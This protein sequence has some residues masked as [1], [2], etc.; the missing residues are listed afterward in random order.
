M[1]LLNKQDSYPPEQR[2]YAARVADILKNLGYTPKACVITYGCQQNV[3]D[4]ERIKGQL[5]LMGYDFT[6]EPADAD[7]ILFNTCA[8]RGHA[9]DRVYGNVG[10]MKHYKRR[11]PNLLL[12]VCGCMAQQESVSEL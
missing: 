11:K 10:A 2:A 5:A 9:E 3:S 1:T 7:F 4:S 8:V 12:C 6:D